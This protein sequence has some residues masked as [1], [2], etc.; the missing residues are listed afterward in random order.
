MQFSPESGIR[1]PYSLILVK[2]FIVWSFTLLVCLLVVGFPLVV[3]LATVG[4]LATVVLQTV[5]PIGAVL[6]VASS[7][8]GGILLTILFGAA[9]LTFKGIHPEE[10]SW[11]RWLH[12]EAE[13]APSSV[14]A[15]CPL[16]CVLIS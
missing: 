6:V 1:T 13:K 2:S 15:S 12:G 7:I 16:A 11:L 4:A 8:V 5:M 9:M 3:L 14:Y 10:V